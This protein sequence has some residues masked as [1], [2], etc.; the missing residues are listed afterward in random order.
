[1][2]GG[3][4]TTAGATHQS[5]AGTHRDRDVYTF[6]YPV[7]AVGIAIPNIAE[8]NGMNRENSGGA[9]HPRGSQGEPF[10]RQ[11]KQIHGVADLGQP[12]P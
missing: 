5:N 2:G 9:G 3:G 8:A 11:L 12:T 4:F 7:F 6:K 10:N 1:M